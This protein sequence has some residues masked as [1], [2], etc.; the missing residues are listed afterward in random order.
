MRP[1]VSIV[2]PSFQQGAFIERTLE[3]I[4]LQDRGTL[5]GKIEH[6]VMD[7]GSTDGTVAIL[8]RWRDRISFW[9]APDGG[10]TDAINRGLAKARGGILAYL[11]SDDIYYEGAVAAALEAFDRDPTADVVYGDADH[12]DVDDRVLG[13]YPT[14][15]WSAA[16]LKLVCFLCQPAVFFRRR[17]VERFGPFDAKLDYCMDYEYWLRLAM[18]GARFVRIPARLAGSRLHKDTKTLGSPV[19]VHTEINEMFR[20]RI[21]TIPDNWLSNYAHAVLDG[22]GVPRSA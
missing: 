13:S 2:T 11:N 16:R 14:E 20:E 4:R 8:E 1:L 15:E 9:S 18:G 21:G 22:R 17:V 10:Q 19:E 7:G 6:I 5:A 12:I 3:S